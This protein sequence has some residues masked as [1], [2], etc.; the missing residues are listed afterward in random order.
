MLGKPDR[1]IHLQLYFCKPDP[2]AWK[3]SGN[4]GSQ[5]EYFWVP[6]VR[7]G[8]SLQ[9]LCGSDVHSIH[10]SIL[11]DSSLLIQMYMKLLIWTELQDSSDS[12][13]LLSL[14]WHRPLP[15][16]M[17]LSAKGYLMVYDQIMA[18]TDGGP[19]TAATSIAVLIYKKG[20]WRRTVRLP[21][22]QCSCAFSS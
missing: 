12:A 16:N 11:Q 22:S 20:F 5:C 2:G 9:Y 8:E 14:F 10:W 17:V 21:V 15:F 18:M 6:T 19:G 4:R 7:C 3:N 1:G 13:R